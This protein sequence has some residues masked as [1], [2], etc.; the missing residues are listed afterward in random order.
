MSAGNRRWIHYQYIL[1][2][3]SVKTPWESLL[4]SVL[5]LKKYKTEPSSD[6]PGLYEIMWPYQVWRSQLVGHGTRVPR[7]KG[8]GI[9][10]L[11]R[12]WG[13]GA[14]S[15]TLPWKVPLAACLYIHTLLGVYFRNNIF[16]GVAKCATQILPA[17]QIPLQL[18]LILHALTCGIHLFIAA[19]NPLNYTHGSNLHFI[20]RP[21]HYWG[22]SALTVAPLR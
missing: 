4:L 3:W 21:L 18:G 22:N 19:G 20:H 17:P 5:V 14:N 16:P 12:G 6:S 11:P 13:R 7:S 8:G 10:D 2:T 15:G 9:P 1:V